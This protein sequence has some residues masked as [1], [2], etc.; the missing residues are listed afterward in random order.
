VSPYFAVASIASSADLIPNARHITR[1]ATLMMLAE[2][3]AKNFRTAAMEFNV[4]KE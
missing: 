4:I 3:R 1:N 2:W